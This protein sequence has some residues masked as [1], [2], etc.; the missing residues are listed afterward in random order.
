MT[1]DKN[2]RK[3][4]KHSHRGI[5]GI[6]VSLILIAV[7]VVGGISVFMFTQGFISDTSV[8]APTIDVV[9]I[10]GYDTSDAN[11]LVPHTGATGAAYT[12]NAASVDSILDDSDAFALYVRNRGSGTVVITSIEIYGEAYSASA[13][14]APCVPATPIPGLSEFSISPDG[15]IAN[16]GQTSI[17]SGEEVTIWV[18]YAQST[19]GEVAL[20]RPIPVT[21]ITANGMEISKQ[22][23]N[24]AQVG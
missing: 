6:I 11:I 21:L 14:A 18:R 17:A 5:A 10:F 9:E 12:I 2:L 7:A 24:G 15:D 16:C 23:T 19:N 1:Y 22:L 4:V 3:F 8:S 20:G 13:A